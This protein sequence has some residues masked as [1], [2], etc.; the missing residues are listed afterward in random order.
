MRITLDKKEDKASPKDLEVYTIELDAKTKAEN[1]KTR[2]D[3][4]QI[5]EKVLVVVNI[6]IIICS[7]CVLFLGNVKFVMR[8]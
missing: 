1:V 7:I 4:M 3:L 8:M 5:K 6:I 2:L